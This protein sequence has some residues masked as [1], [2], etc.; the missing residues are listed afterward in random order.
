MIDVQDKR[1]VED[2]MEYH[3]DSLLDEDPEI[4]EKMAQSKLQGAQTIIVTFLEARFPSLAELG[5]QK[6]TLIRSTDI[7]NLLAKQIATAPDESTARWLLDT[8]AA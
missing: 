2:Y 5:Q 1:I 3:Y 4:K 7:L 6:V 8:I